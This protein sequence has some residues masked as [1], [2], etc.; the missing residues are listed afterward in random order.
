[1]AYTAWS[2]IAGEQPTAAKWN[3]LGTNDASFNDAT[4]I[5]TSVIDYTKVA[6]GVAVQFSRL[7]DFSALLQLAQPLFRVTT[8]FRR[9]LKATE[10]LSASHHSEGDYPPPVYRVPLCS[11]PL[12][13]PPVTSLPPSSKTL[14]SNALAAGW[15]T[16]A[17]T[18]YKNIVT[19][20]HEMAAGTTSATTPSKSGQAFRR[21]AH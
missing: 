5:G 6:A 11:F 13:W 7:A 10:Y 17:N 14:L 21:L 8:P 4:G 9:T 12:R 2:V 1:M 15:F 20:T 16:Q 19:V 18:T 3:I